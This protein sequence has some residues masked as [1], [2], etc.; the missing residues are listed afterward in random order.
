MMTLYQVC[1]GCNKARDLKVSESGRYRNN[2]E[3]A[4]SEGWYIVGPNQH[5]C[6]ACIKKAL[7]E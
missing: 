6:P 5:L 2:I 4:Q 1:D 7:A 3:A